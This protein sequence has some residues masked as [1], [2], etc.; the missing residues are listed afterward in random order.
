[1]AKKD[2]NII[3]YKK[4]YVN[5]LNKK[6]NLDITNNDIS[7]IIENGTNK[8]TYHADLDHALIKAENELQKM[9]LEHQKM[10]NEVEIEFNKSFYNNKIIKNM[11]I[12]SKN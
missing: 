9:M 7:I 1:M 2:Q 10:I 11:P 5:N 4:I 6:I 8:Q 12:M 3:N